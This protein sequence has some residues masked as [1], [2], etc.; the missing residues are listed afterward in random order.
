[1]VSLFWLSLAEEVMAV[2]A[3]RGGL[4]SDSMVMSVLCL[5]LG[6]VLD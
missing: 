4:G 5:D 1:M 2:L 6:G 3:M